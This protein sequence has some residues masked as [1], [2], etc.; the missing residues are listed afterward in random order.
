M[1]EGQ[2][3]RGMGSMGH[4]YELR[5]LNGQLTHSTVYQHERGPAKSFFA[6]LKMHEVLHNITN[7]ENNGRASPIV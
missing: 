4:H 6:I 5:E 2:H 7:E 3:E 1:I